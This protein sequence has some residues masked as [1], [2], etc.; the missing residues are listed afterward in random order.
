MEATIPNISFDLPTSIFI[1]IISIVMVALLAGSEAGI[2]SVN[3]IKVKNLENNGDKRSQA[4]SEL[5]RNH[6]KLFATILTVENAFI[7]LAS[8]ISATL[9]HKMFG[10][11]GTLVTSFIMTI[12]IV[13]FGEITPKTFA[14]Q[15]SE[16]IAL[17]VARPIRLLV[18]VLNYPILILTTSTK[19]IIFILNKLGFG[20][21]GTDEFSITEGEIRMMIDEGEL[22]QDDKELLKNVFDFKD[23][24]ASDVMVP[25]TMINAVPKNYTVRETLLEMVTYR[26]S[27]MPIY[28]ETIDN[29]LGIVNLKDLVAQ[30]IE[31]EAVNDEKIEKFI[32]PVLFIPESKKVKDV[33]EL[34]QQKKIQMCVVTDEFGGTEG[35]ITIQDLMEV[36]IDDIEDSDSNNKENGNFETIDENTFVLHG[37]SY[38][39][40][41]NEELKVNIPEGNYQTIAGFILNKLGKIPSVGEKFFHENLE[42]IINEVVGPKIVK[43]TIINHKK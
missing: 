5:L 42:I 11:I 41:I 8:S 26:H 6:D 30:I 28:D 31:N 36:I 4:I 22:Q 12:I 34:M 14:A 43:V 32:I 33:L 23:S 3:K 13:I 39:E 10:E 9:A 1:I 27:K 20:T 37:T 7:I 25:R 35:I 2:L 17:L 16:L 21:K 38:I 29:I 15:N 24:V 40:D 18:K 19:G